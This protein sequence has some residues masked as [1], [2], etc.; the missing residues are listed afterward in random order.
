MNKGGSMK[1]VISL[2]AV[3]TTLT[4]SNVYADNLS[5]RPNIFGG[6][7]IYSGFDRVGSTRPNI[8]GGQDIYSGFDRVGSTR[9]NI[10]GG[11]DLK[12]CRMAIC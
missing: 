4:F 8:F 7:D 1:K 11:V 3:I 6:Q 9:P 10:F 12:S 5:T 2:L